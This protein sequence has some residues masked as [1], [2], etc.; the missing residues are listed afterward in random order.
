MATTHETTG[1][2]KSFRFGLDG[3]EAAIQR[4]RIITSTVLGTCALDRELGILDD[5]Q[6]ITT[7]GSRQLTIARVLTALQEQAPEITVLEV[8]LIED[9]E[10]ERTGR[11]VPLIRFVMTEEVDQ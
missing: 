11:L 5:G 8:D 4:I 2:Y 9:E 3:V 6:D 1:T 7:L 10:Y